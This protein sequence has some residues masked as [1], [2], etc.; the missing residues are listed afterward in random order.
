MRQLDLKR[1][2][3]AIIRGRK[4]LGGLPRADGVV[5]WTIET[6]QL[7][8]D[9]FNKTSLW[10]TFVRGYQGTI[11][12]PTADWVNEEGM[13]RHLR[14]RVETVEAALATVQRRDK[15]GPV[16]HDPLL[17]AS[18]VA[19]EIPLTRVN[20]YISGARAAYGL[21]NWE[22]AVSR[23]A[24]AFERAVYAI[25]DLVTQTQAPRDFQGAMVIITEKGVITEETKKALCVRDVSLWGWVCLKGRQAEG[26]A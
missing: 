26:A 10:S 1:L 8:L 9:L 25:A 11:V 2:K 3:S 17:E 19:L 13:R 20:D 21:E 12:G 6:E 7:L 4:L 24:K 22:E 5:A 14:H 18:R 16:P 23:I 15:D